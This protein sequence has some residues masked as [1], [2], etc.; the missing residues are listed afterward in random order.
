MDDPASDVAFTPAVK[1]VQERRGSRR[2]Y[3]RM[4][5][6]AGWPRR[7][8]PELAAFIAERDSFF[9]ATASAQG[10]PYMQ[11]RGGPKGFLRVVDER[12]LA[13]PEFNGNRQYIT[14]GNLSENDRALLFLIDYASRRRIRIWGR[15]RVLDGDMPPALPHRA[16]A[17]SA[18]PAGLMV[19]EVET[20]NEN[21]PQHIPRLVAHD[22][23]LAIVRARDARI[24]ALEVELARCRSLPRP[25]A[26][27]SK[28]VFAGATCAG[29]SP[30]ERRL[31]CTQDP[32]A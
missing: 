24:A 11:H 27:A 16:A 15:A 6:G 31:P 10:Q 22:K 25:D 4:E 12:T 7:I 32:L 9:I 13:F 26:A 20:W 23:L 18:P 19:F 28:S 21:C 3:A 8:T 14:A 1:A 17:E 2:A 30:T 5:H 29:T